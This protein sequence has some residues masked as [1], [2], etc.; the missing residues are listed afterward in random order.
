MDLQKGEGVTIFV[1]DQSH[2]FTSHNICFATFAR[3]G[4]TGSTGS[5]GG[6]RRAG[7]EELGD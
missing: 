2:V 4:S 1:V 5:P 7:G 6:I 3:A